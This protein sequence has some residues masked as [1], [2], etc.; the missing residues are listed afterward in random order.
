MCFEGV[1]VIE[2]RMR[3]LKRPHTDWQKGRVPYQGLLFSLMKTKS[4][5]KLFF[6]IK[7]KKNTPMAVLS[8]PPS[9]SRKHLTFP[10]H[11]KFLTK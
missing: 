9:I 10:A 1:R 8:Q 4:G 11:F 5:V 7:K 3:A 2:G 6:N